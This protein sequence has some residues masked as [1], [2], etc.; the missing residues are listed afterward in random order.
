MKLNT[1]KPRVQSAVLTFVRRASTQSQ[2]LT[3]SA[4]QD[5][6]A[7]ILGAEPLCRPCHSEER[8]TA[9]IEVDH[10]IPLHEGGADDDSNLQ[11]I[12]LRCHHAKSAR[13]AARRAR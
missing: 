7:R 11:P 10:V 4:L 1:L 9:A 2:R 8:L 13:E 12:C 6:N 3:G 5:R